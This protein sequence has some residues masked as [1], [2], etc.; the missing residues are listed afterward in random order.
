MHAYALNCYRFV[1]LHLQSQKYVVLNSLA[2][3]DIVM[4]DPPCQASVLHIGAPGPE[5]VGPTSEMGNLLQSSCIRA[6]VH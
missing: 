6:F 3:G 5:P 2:K 4:Y 1:T